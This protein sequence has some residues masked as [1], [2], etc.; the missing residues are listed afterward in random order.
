MIQSV[1]EVIIESGFQVVGWV[2]LKAVTFGRYRGFQPEDVL[3]EGSL[4]LATVAVVG[5][6]GYRLMF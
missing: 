1:I 2:V 5:Y 3:V 6:G 4:G